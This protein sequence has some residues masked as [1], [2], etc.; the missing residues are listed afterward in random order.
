MYARPAVRYHA[1]S[2]STYEVAA[3]AGP[4][5][6]PIMI[7]PAP[8]ERVRPARP[9]S[10]THVCCEAP[11]PTH[12]EVAGIAAGS[13]AMR[14]CTPLVTIALVVAPHVIVGPVAVASMAAK[15]AVVTVTA[16]SALA[17][18]WQPDDSRQGRGLPASVTVSALGPSARAGAFDAMEQVMR[19]E[20]AY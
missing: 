10:R 12:E 2:M 15:A 5:A 20:S 9:S 4:L 6:S 1:K 7:V 8:R 11:E 3:L 18:S 14:G 16:R 19:P 13:P 17:V